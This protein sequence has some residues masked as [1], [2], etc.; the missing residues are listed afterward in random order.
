MEGEG[1]CARAHLLQEA[2]HGKSVCP[3]AV[4][5]GARLFT[6]EPQQSAQRNRQP[7]LGPEG[8]CL[9]WVPRGLDPVSAWEQVGRSGGSRLGFSHPVA[10]SGVRSTGADP[11]LVHTGPSTRWLGWGQEGLNHDSSPALEK[12]T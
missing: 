10:G 11:G 6:P 5:R 12:A 4:W 2:W 8:H 7:P 3:V 1:D 9:R